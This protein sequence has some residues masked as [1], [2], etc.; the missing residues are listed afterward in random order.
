VEDLYFIFESDFCAALAWL[1][2]LSSQKSL[3]Q[4]FCQAKEGIM[5]FIGEKYER[6]VTHHERA[7]L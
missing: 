3:L 5:S 6:N 1:I 2:L 4:S 7:L